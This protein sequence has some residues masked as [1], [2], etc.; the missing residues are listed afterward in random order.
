VRH[1]DSDISIVDQVFS[2]GREYFDLQFSD[3]NESQKHEPDQ[4]REHRKERGIEIE[5]IL[6]EKKPV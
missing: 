5:Q 3:L 2:E 6:I 4:S 1:S